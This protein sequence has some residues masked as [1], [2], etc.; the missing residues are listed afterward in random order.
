MEAEYS[1]IKMELWEQKMGNRLLQYHRMVMLLFQEHSQP[2]MERL[3][4][5]QLEISMV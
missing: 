2:P 1:S 4:V 5:S 3:E